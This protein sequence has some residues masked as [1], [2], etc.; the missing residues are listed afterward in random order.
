MLTKTKD[1]IGSFLKE[2]KLSLEQI[3]GQTD[4]IEKIIKILINARD[5]GNKIYTMGNGG[6][7]S[8]ASHF[9]SD[10]LKTAITKNNK[11]FSAIALTDNMPVILAWSN[12]TSYD[13]VF[14]EQLKNFLSKG[15]VIVGFSGSGKSKN[16]VKAMTY[17]KKNGAICIGITGMAGGDFPKICDVYLI[18]PS[19]DMLGIEST[20]VTLCH[21]IISAIRNLGKPMFTYD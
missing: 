19:N 11:R 6:S 10:L 7:A 18:V 21:C 1:A 16:V 20:H 13:A 9:V 3:S 14:V 8:T 4:I 15:D 2:Q 12:D 5:K 17:G